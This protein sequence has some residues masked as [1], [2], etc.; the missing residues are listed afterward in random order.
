MH[1][2]IKD[3]IVE[4]TDFNS[5]LEEQVKGI[6]DTK[7]KSL[8]LDKDLN[9]VKEALN[10]M[11]EVCADKSDSFSFTAADAKE[12]QD[13]TYA[14]LGVS[15]GA[16]CS[17]AGMGAQ[18]T[19]IGTAMVGGPMLLATV[20]AGIA[21]VSIWMLFKKNKDNRKQEEQEKKSDQIAQQFVR[22]IM[23]KKECLALNTKRFERT[24]GN[25]SKA[26]DISNINLI[27]GLEDFT[28]IFKK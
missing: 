28:N 15:G 6:S 17:L 23:N 7:E 26:R 10:D 9:K 25:S 5:F 8:L 22:K 14:I 12:R 2:F 19:M 1:E 20:A 18:G 11:K 4:C 13:K 16:V 21:I 3:A 24:N 27:Q